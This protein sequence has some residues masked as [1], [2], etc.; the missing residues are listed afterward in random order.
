MR[1]YLDMCA[2]NR[3]YDDQ[4]QLKVLMESQSKL[5]IQE[6]IIEGKYELV[7]SY[8]LDY[9]CSRN[10]FKMRKEAITDFIDKYMSAYVS[11]DRNDVIT[12][13]AN[14]IMKTGVKEKDALHIA[15]AIYAKCEYFI[16][17]DI[18]LLKYRTDEI[19]LVTPIEFILQT[20]GE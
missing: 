8:V 14:E 5:R 4:S 13:K 7:G 12:N 2:Y 10:P 1:I 18:R 9:E 19:K 20:E 15:A 3:P 6:L 17:T 16:S 11:S